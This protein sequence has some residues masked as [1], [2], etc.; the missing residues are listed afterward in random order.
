MHREGRCVPWSRAVWSESESVNL[1][2]CRCCRPQYV[3]FQVLLGASLGL[4]VSV[5]G[6][7]LRAGYVS[8]SPFQSGGSAWLRECVRASVCLCVCMSA[9]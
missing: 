1:H 6:I 8:A 4:C 7:C 2:V 9:G 5:Q 3:R